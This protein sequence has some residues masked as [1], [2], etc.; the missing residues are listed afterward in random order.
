MTYTCHTDYIAQK[1]WKMIHLSDDNN[2]IIYSEKNIWDRKWHKGENT[3]QEAHRRKDTVALQQTKIA[4]RE[5]QFEGNIV[6]HLV[7]F[8]E[9]LTWKYY[10]KIML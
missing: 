4:W 10:N 3:E 7:H 2:I 1:H 5:E 9:L 6:N 8:T